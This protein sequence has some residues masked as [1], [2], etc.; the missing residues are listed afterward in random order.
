MRIAIISLATLVGI[1]AAEAAQVEVLS[2]SPSRI[3]VATSCWA[4][5]SYCQQEAS[6]VA[7]GYCHGKFEESPRRAV[8]VRSGSVEGGLSGRTIFIFRCDRT[9]ITCQAGNC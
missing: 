5:G 3:E 2:A 9:P 6:D 1:G 4:G 7:Q 8:F